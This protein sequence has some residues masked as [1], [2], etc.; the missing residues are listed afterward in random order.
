MLIDPINTKMHL[1]VRSMHHVILA[2]EKMYG[3][4]ELLK[5]VE[6]TGMSLEYL[7][8]QNNWISYDYC[9]KLLKALVEY[10]G[11]PLIPF[12]IGLTALT[13]TGWGVLRLIG[14]SILSCTYAYKKTVSFSPRW[15]KI[16]KFQFLKFKKNSAILEL[17]Y[18]ENFKQ[19][20]NNCLNIQGRLLLSRLSLNLP[21]AK[22]RELQCAAEGADSCIYELSWQNPP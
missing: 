2:F 13:N 14:S 3:K 20:K 8:D 11:D 7:Q 21:P 6:G 17:R 18:L 15:Q 12:K 10:S 19:N 5:F 1:S 16:A 22:I 4:K 9:C